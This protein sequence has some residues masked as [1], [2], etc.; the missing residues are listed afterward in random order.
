MSTE[1][2]RL[3]SKGRVGMVVVLDYVSLPK[4]DPFAKYQ[5]PAFFTIVEDL[6]PEDR[7]NGVYVLRDSEGNLVR[8]ELPKGRFESTI[9]SYLAEVSVWWAWVAA[10]NAQSIAR[11]DAT[12]NDLSIRC[13]VLKEVMQNQG[14]R[15][16]T[17]EQ[18]KTL[19]IGN[20]K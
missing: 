2:T 16:V 14:V 15:V 19:G 8:D 12:I 10:R 3:Y 7:F 17:E 18:A 5:Q 9:A 4:D 13:S 20:P 6:S 1:L 11:R